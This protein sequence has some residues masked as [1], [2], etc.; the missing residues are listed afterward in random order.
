MTWWSRGGGHVPTRFYQKNIKKLSELF[1]I[2]E[3]QIQGAPIKTLIQFSFSFWK[4]L[5]KSG[6]NDT[7]Q[8]YLSDKIS[9]EKFLTDKIVRPFSSYLE[10]SQIL[11]KSSQMTNVVN[12]SIKLTK[13]F[14]H[15]LTSYFFK[16]KKVHNFFEI[17]I[18]LKNVAWINFRDL[19]QK[20]KFCNWFLRNFA[21]RDFMRYCY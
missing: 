19:S 4:V 14:T 20:W 3:V 2:L 16:I 5:I 6:C 1:S 21:Q 12:F 10:F 15:Y 7:I 8:I 18:N 13:S 9:A 17:K 11:S